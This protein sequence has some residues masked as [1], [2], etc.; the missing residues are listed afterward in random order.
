MNM[1]S[2]PFVFNFTMPA[3]VTRTFD[4]TIIDDKILDDYYYYYY[5]NN[6]FYQ[7]DIGIDLGIYEASEMVLCDYSLIR[8]EDND[9]NELHSYICS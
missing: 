8:I 5:Y 1:T 7:E 9:G 2:F 6:S 3:G 4:L